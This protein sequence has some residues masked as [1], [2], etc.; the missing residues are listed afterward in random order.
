[1]RAAVRQQGQCH[2]NPDPDPK[3]GELV[4]IHDASVTL[5][6][7]VALVVLF[8]PPAEDFTDLSRVKV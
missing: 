5:G 4:P 1:M 6:H 2:P 7:S 8:P 3:W